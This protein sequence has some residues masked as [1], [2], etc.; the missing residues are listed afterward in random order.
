MFNG[1]NLHTLIAGVSGSGKSTLLRM[2]L[3]KIESEADTK[4][5]LIDPKRTEL[6]KYKRSLKTLWYASMPDDI[7]DVLSRVDCLMETRFDR[8]SEAGQTVSSEDDVFIVVDEMAPLMQGQGRKEYIQLF[9]KI[10]LLGRAA[11]V[12][13]ILCTQVATQDVIPAC[14]RD[15]MAN[16]VCLRQR[17]PRKYSYLLGYT[18]GRLPEYGFAY[19]FTP[20][21]YDRPEKYRVEDVWERITA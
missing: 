14:I 18:P 2:V 21:M 16:I 13:M 7:S 9:S 20:D 17:D 12:H 19:V 1:K 11:R 4:F 5:V 8:M 6:I 10:A 15:N 3:D